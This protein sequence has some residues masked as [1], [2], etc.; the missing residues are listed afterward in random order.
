[1][2]NLI[3]WRHAEAAEC[4]VPLQ[5]PQRK[6]TVRGEKQA[7]RMARWLDRQL[8]QS[9]RI[10]VSPAV[11]AVQTAAALGRSVKVCP[12][13]APNAPC[14]DLL[15]T[16]LPFKN[17]GH[18]LLVGHQPL[19]GQLIG[20]LLDISAE[21]CQIKKGAVWWLRHKDRDPQGRTVLLTVQHPD[22]L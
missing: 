1:M 6:L 16:L 10:W 3:I 5:D 8:P 20:Q 15:A 19:L 21:H 18:L 17:K 11:R 9:T 12:E 7:A 4:S 13:L 14:T 2:V 22:M